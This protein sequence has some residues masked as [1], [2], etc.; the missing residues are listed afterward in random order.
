MK[1]N[2]TR[3]AATTLVNG[4]QVD[5]LIERHDGRG[6]FWSVT[7]PSFSARYVSSGNK[8][9][10]KADRI[11]AEKAASITIEDLRKETKPK[12]SIKPHEKAED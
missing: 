12:P 7:W 3:F 9:G 11:D 10:M 5:A 4:K 1:W 8:R 2:P 6:W